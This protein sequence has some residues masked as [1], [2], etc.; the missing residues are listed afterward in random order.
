[1]PLKLNPALFAG[2]AWGLGLIRHLPFLDWVRRYRRQDLAGDLMAGV[3]VAVMLVPQS[4]AYA[5]LVGLPPQIGLYASIAPLIIYGLLGSS[6]TLSVGPAAIVALLVASGVGQLASQG[7]AQYL[8]LVLLLTLMVGCLQLV[9]GLA[10]LGFLVN[11]LSHPVITGFTSAAALVIIFSQLPHLL[12]VRLPEGEVP[13]QPLVSAFENIT[14]VNL[15]T[16]GLGFGGIAILVYFKSLLRRHLGLLA[17][18]LPLVEV[19]SRAGPL[20]VVLAGTLLVWGLGL[21]QQG[22]VS[23]VGEVPAGLP[24]LT[25]PELERASLMSLLPTALAISFVGFMESIA[26]AKT[27]ATR[28]RQKIEANQELAALGSANLG[29]AFTSGFPVAGGLS[30]SMVNFA[31]GANTGLAS[32]ITASLIVL[33]VLLLV[34]LFFFLPQVVLAAIIVVG[35]VELIDLS[36]FKRVWRYSKADGG[37]MLITFGGAL[38]VSVE[39]GILAGVATSLALYL[40]RTSRPQIAIVGRVEESEHF[41]NISRFRVTTYPQILAVRVDESLYFPNTRYLEDTLRRMIVD[42][43]DVKHLVLIGSGINYI[44]ASGLA[45]LEA[46][47]EQLQE[48]GVNFYLAEIKGPVLEQLRRADFLDRLGIEHIFVT[49]HLAM[50]ALIQGEQPQIRYDTIMTPM[51]PATPEDS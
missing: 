2:K 41:R 40:W 15:I 6:R 32:I 17:A 33:T 24:S 47:M 3:V 12:G 14:R 28:R 38:A 8:S 30:R 27:L 11:F 22:N 37:A 20:V 1:M 7:S 13:Y 50:Q 26:I 51:T 34:P 39:A 49:T 5:L 4:M 23:V 25:V 21:S 9:M 10:R 44:D 29:A 35:V 43:P 45:T 36:T 48:A 46:L 16:V 31:A 19:V 42:H 18:P